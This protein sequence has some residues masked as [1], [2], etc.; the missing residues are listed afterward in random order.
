M[1]RPALIDLSWVLCC[2]HRNIWRSQRVRECALMVE[3]PGKAHLPGPAQ[4][5]GP[6]WKPG[7]AGL[8]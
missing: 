5:P 4:T 3:L 7:M 1:Q 8:L 2:L 6:A